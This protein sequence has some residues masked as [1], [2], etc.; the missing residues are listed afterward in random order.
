MIVNIKKKSSIKKYY[1]IN[2]KLQSIFQK[3]YSKYLRQIKII[4]PIGSY[5]PE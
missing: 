2:A 5:W 3:T 4:V 1:K